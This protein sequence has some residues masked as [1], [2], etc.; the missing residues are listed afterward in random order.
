MALQQ[1]L[2][3]KSISLPSA[4]F[5]V[6]RPSVDP[7][8]TTMSFGLWPYPTQDAASDDANMLGAAAVTFNDVAY[9]VT[10]ANI[11]EQAY[12]YLKTLP[13]YAN[14]TDVL[15]PGQTS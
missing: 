11:F 9:D 14:A 10:G 3:Y 6:V 4:Y 7:G 13:E 2:T 8:K 12:V 5:R 15:E 1:A